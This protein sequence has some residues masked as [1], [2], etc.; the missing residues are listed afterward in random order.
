MRE[1][2]I[3]RMLIQYLSQKK[4]QVLP[5]FINEL[6]VDRFRRRVDVVKVD[7]HLSAYEIKSDQDKIVRLPGQIETFKNYMPFLS[8]TRSLCL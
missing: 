4:N 1:A 8:Q 3:R 5:Q 6:F 2:E 7:Q